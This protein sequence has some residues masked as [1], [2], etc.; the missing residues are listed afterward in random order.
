MRILHTSDWHLG[1]S[2]HG[3][4]LLEAPPL[5]V[6]S[7]HHFWV[8]LSTR[9]AAAGTLV[10]NRLHPGVAVCRWPRTSR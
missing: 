5:V 4:G 6:T 1:R 8:A 9:G 7:I 2:F 10:V 3:A